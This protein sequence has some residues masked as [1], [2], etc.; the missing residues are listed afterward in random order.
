M[1]KTV[2]AAPGFWD[3]VFSLK[4]FAAAMLALWIALT[5]DLPN[6]YW[7]VGAVYI[8]AH[9]LSGATTSKA[10]YRLIGTV[11]GGIACVVMVPNLIDAPELLTLALALWMGGCLVVSLL[12]RS[13]RS[14]AFML[15][16]YTA[17]LTSFAIVSAPQTAFDYAVGR[18]E[19]IAIG[20]VCAAL[21]SRLVFPR[22]AGPVLAARI[23]AWLKD[24]SR[25]ALESLR[26]DGGTPAALADRR[27]L[28]ADAVDLNAFTTH[29][30]YDTSAL[31]DIVPPLRVLQRRMVA[32]LP[33]VSGITDLIAARARMDDGCEARGRWPAAVQALVDETCIW[34][35]SGGELTEDRRAVL[36]A[37]LA[38]VEEGARETVQWDSLL[39]LNF[40]A[41]ICD[42]VQV[43]SDCIDLRG[44]IASGARRQLRW[45]RYDA[46]VENRPMHRD[47]GMA[48]MS[49]FSVVLATC[50]TTA[51][52]IAT[53]WPHGGGAVMM[54]GIFCCLF[55]T[56]DD[57]VP[58]MKKF[59]WLLLPVTG[60]AF[61]FE[62]AVMPLVD[63]FLPLAL[64]LGLFLVP[65]GILLAI[66]S[67]FLVGM[68][69]CVNLPYMLMLQSRAT[70]D[71]GTFLNSNLATV[72]GIAAAACV[73]S[74][75]RSV[76]A[77]WS[78]RRLVRAGWSDIVAA[79]EGARS[80]NRAA[81]FDAL[82]Y[83]M[84]DRFGLLAPRLAAI[85]AGSDVAGTDLVRDLRNGL[86]I[87]DLRAH[88]DALPREAG[89]AV[90]AALA[91][92]GTYYGTLGGR[93][94]GVGSG[95]NAVFLLTALDAAL[96]AVL[97]ASGSTAA[98]RARLAL[99]SLRCT[100]FPAAP[101]FQ[102][103]EPVPLL[104][105]A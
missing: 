56:M 55:A 61:V 24:G 94:A 69:L 30:A 17:A 31:R 3:V 52:W 98:A 8:V 44:E 62:F 4:T 63:G 78:A 19:E 41:R 97:A 103:P 79:A 76:G 88:R 82:L 43:W 102:G 40:A 101:P 85:P 51:L 105:A 90:E 86:N 104:K 21:V 10:V 15:A 74:L 16:G 47:W 20:I 7:A 73:T 23:D 28:A 27:R 38:A 68:V 46:K 33:V 45:Q 13:P 2:A 39:A 22:H 93:E 58:V 75:V 92:A 59:C 12:D 77:E 14:Y 91:A 100:L 25:L 35:E 53:G 89:D 65:A 6:P 26:G 54:A 95:E 9:P 99:V 60:A 83:R 64:I 11:V 81:A 36:L 42:L 49:G 84:L 71:L 57:P 80:A 50:L 29:I 48:L 1:T 96:E 37:R 72:V 66:P 87:I 70:H 18:V 67:R 5:F 32:L 34:L